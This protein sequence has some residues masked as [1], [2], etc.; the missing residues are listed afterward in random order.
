[1]NKRTLDQIASSPALVARYN[2]LQGATTSSAEEI[3]KLVS[4]GDV[5]AIH[6]VCSAAE[7]L[8][9][10]TGLLTNV[11]DPGTVI[12]G[13]GLGLADGLYWD[14]FISSTR[15]HIWW[16]GH[17][18]LPI[19]RAGCGESAGFVGAAAFAWKQSEK[20]GL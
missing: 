6:V 14:D 15:R 4:D 1:V 17:R 18:G 2:R 16:E 8:G 10:A 13:G 9:V 11:L 7:A 19:I 5:E 20:L 3:L 12:V